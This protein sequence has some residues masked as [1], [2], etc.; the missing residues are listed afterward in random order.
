MKKKELIWL[1]AIYLAISLTIF[2]ATFLMKRRFSEEWLE[3]MIGSHGVRQQL[4]E[5]PCAYSILGDPNAGM[6]YIKIFLACKNGK[7]SVST[8]DA[9]AIKAD[10]LES[11]LLEF[12]RINGIS[13]ET[14]RYRCKID[15]R[16][17][18]LTTK[19]N[20]QATMECFYE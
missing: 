1:A 10:T 9:K 19:L 8:F 15:S 4:T 5:D 2:G 17:I 6:N 14:K 18:T 12:Q 7:K 11:F 13:A 16:P 3:R 20:N